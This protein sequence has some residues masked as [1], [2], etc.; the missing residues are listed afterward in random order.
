MKKQLLLCTVV[1]AGLACAPQKPETVPTTSTRTKNAPAWID[2]PQAVAGIVGVGVE[3]PN[4][5]GD[6]MM[7]RKVALAAARAEIAKQL[8]VQ[9]QGVFSRLDQQYKTAGVDGKKPISSEAMSRMIDDTQR[10]VVNVSLAGATPREYWTDPETKQLWVLVTIDKESADRAIKAA[11]SS[12]IR[13]EIAHGEKGLQ[14]ALDRL[15]ATLARQ[16]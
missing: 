2:N 6:I 13:K 3:A 8:N 11:A 15:D 10:E 16:Q 7:Q 9:A 12:A 5:M 14:D 1:L 4:V